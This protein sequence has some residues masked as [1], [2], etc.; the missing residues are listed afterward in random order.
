MSCVRSVVASVR[1]LL[2]AGLVLGMV[3]ACDDPPKRT[4]RRKSAD[5]AVAQA[6]AAPEDPLK[7]ARAWVAAMPETHPEIVPTPEQGTSR[8]SLA[9]TFEDQAYTV[10]VDIPRGVLAGARAATRG[11]SFREGTPP[12]TDLDARINLPMVLDPAQE[13]VF[14]ALIRELRAIRDR[15][16]LDEDRYFELMLAMV[17]AIP[18][19]EHAK[20]GRFPIEVLAD[21][22]GDCDEKARL[23]AGLAAREGYGVA[24]LVFDADEHMAVGIRDPSNGFRG[25]PWAFVETTTPSLVTFPFPDPE[26]PEM[27]RDPL[28]VEVGAGT[29]GYGAGA[30]IRQIVDGKRRLQELLAATRDELTRADQA[31][32]ASR[33]R[34]EA[35]E[36]TVERSNGRDPANAK[37]A[38]D[39]HA[40]GVRTHNTEVARLREQAAAHDADVALYNAIVRGPTSRAPLAARL[41]ARFSRP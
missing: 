41:R 4:K 25:T 3:G 30:D 15:T 33:A 14:T 32:D 37:A 17:Q 21:G 36:R 26:K 19:D 13:P 40:E 39:A 2:W 24:L 8:A 22:R 5:V 28:V 6:P 16:T 11:I 35:L 27:K 31:L 23:L 20:D 12:P 38:L 29:R 1:G 18:Y 34:L 10:A 9:F 7:A